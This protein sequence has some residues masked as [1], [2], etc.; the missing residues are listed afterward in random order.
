[1]ISGFDYKE[2]WADYAQET[3]R[4]LFGIRSKIEDALKHA[5]GTHTFDDVVYLV[6]SGQLAWFVADDGSSIILTEIQ[7]YPRKRNVHAFL[8]AGELK[9]LVPLARE[10]MEFYMA[11]GFDSATLTGRPGW[12]R[13][14]DKLGWEHVHST[15]SFDAPRTAPI[16]RADLTPERPSVNGSAQYGNV[17]RYEANSPAEP[18]PG[19]GHSGPTSEKPN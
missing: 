14:F 1:M 5:H 6:F 3:V 15:M 9:T 4:R 11:L 13:V 18:I 12:V 19:W 10:V 8:A 17:S 2:S 16:L 7:V